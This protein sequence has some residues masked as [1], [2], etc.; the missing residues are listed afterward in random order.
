[1]KFKSL[2][3]ESILEE[4]EMSDSESSSSISHEYGGRMLKSQLKKIIMDSVK[5]HDNTD[6]HD[7]I[8]PW[9]VD[10]I[11]RAMELVSQ[12]SGYVTGLEDEDSQDE[13]SGK[14]IMISLGGK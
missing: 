3:K 4:A 12:V 6:N 8:D 9:V 5:I 11:A 1:M 13:M 7:K 10:H 2:L 14:E